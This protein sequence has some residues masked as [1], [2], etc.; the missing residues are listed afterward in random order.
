MTGGQGSYT[1]EF[2]GYEAVPPN[3]QQ[4]IIARAKIKKEEG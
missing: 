1:L 2:A 3:V 4:E